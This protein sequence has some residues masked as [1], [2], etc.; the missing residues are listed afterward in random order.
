MPADCS[1]D[2]PPRGPGSPRPCRRSRAQGMAREE[3]GQQL[4]RSLWVALQHAL[5]GIGQLHVLSLWHPAAQRAV[6]SPDIC[7]GAGCSD[8]EEWLPERTASARRMARTSGQGRR[9]GTS[10]RR[11]R[12]TAR[13]TPAA[14]FDRTSQGSHHRR[15]PAR[16]LDRARPV[17]EV[18]WD[19]GER[20]IE[21]CDRL[22]C[23]DD[24][25]D[26]RLQDRDGIYHVGSIERQLQD[27]RAAGGLIGEVRR[28]DSQMLQ[29]ALQSST[30]WPMLT[31]PTAGELL[32]Q[33]RR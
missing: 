10:C 30:P 24:R 23:H 4:G 7:P 26:E 9:F 27:D 1:V 15:P 11:L 19:D 28:F 29:D 8:V 20:G 25:G 33:P 5:G 16:H 12:P 13:S 3:V 31:G 18:R 22:S 21:V 32:P 6:D 14:T 17:T 2:R